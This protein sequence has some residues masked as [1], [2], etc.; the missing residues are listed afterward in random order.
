MVN[1]RMD[2]HWTDDPTHNSL[3]LLC[4]VACWYDSLSSNLPHLF[5][6]NN[7]LCFSSVRSYWT[8]PNFP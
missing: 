3:R 5:Y 1:D 6:W 4:T 8:T 2:G 7:E